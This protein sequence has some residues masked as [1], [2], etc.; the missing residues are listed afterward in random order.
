MIE[1]K[2]RVDDRQQGAVALSAWSEVNRKELF[3]GASPTNG[4]K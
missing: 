3:V 1:E 2:E 4:R